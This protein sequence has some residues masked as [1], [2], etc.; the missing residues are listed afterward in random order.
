MT[1]DRLEILLQIYDG[2]IN[3]MHLAIAGLKKNDIPAFCKYLLKAQ[4][5]VVELANTL[6]Y[7]VDPDLCDKLHKVYYAVLN[8]LTEANLTKQEKYILASIKCIEKLA[9]AYREVGAKFKNTSTEQSNDE[10]SL[11]FKFDF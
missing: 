11:E 10:I 6:D 7:S 5:C 2:C 9:S 3:F 1:A 8:L 4:D